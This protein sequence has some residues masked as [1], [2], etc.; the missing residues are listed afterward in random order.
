[1][2]KIYGM[3]TCPYCDYVHEQIKGR[4][5]EF[6]YMERQREEQRQD[7]DAKAVQA[8]Y[9]QMYEEYCSRWQQYSDTYGIYLEVKPSIVKSELT[10]E[11]SE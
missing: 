7:Y 2:I 8:Y 9:E 11:V 3:P 5:D 6:E 1:M 4:E 10:I